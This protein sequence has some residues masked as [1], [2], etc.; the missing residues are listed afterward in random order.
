MQRF[1]LS[2]WWIIAFVVICAGCGDAQRTE[3]ASKPQNGTEATD[4]K[5]QRDAE[6]SLTEKVLLAKIRDIRNNPQEFIIWGT[7]TYSHEG[8]YITGG[9][10]I[11]RDCT[12]ITGYAGQKVD[13]SFDIWNGFPSRLFIGRPR[14]AMNSFRVI[15]VG[16]PTEYLLL[17]EMRL[18]RNHQDQFLL[19]GVCGYST[20]FDIP[21][22]LSG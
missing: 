13:I 11:S 2:Q 16:E 1:R 20:T 15:A 7:R 17:P 10:G 3:V 5:L 4:P 9:L 18:G 12:L 19:G 14:V 22:L 21:T 6:Q 8:L